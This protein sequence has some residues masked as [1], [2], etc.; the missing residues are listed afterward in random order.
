MIA[1]SPFRERRTY[2]P[3]IPVLAVTLNFYCDVT[4]EVRPEPKIIQWI[5][6]QTADEYIKGFPAPNPLPCT[7]RRQV[8]VQAADRS[9][10]INP[11][12]D[13][14]SIR[15]TCRVPLGAP[16][17]ICAVSLL[18]QFCGSARFPTLFGQVVTRLYSNRLFN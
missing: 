6:A 5:D 10:G 12:K 15:H 11:V 4:L 2:I 18:M 8:Q 3:E 13:V 14:E 1:Q 16:F 7:A 9:Q 17:C